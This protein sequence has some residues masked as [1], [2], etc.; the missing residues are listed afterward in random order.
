MRYLVKT[1]Q[2]E[3]V[4]VT[5][6]AVEPYMDQHLNNVKNIVFVLFAVH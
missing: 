2:D 3:G 4:Q 5:A 1:R 6:V